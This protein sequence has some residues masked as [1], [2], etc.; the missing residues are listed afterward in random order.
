MPLL[1]IIKPLFP[2]VPNMPG[3]PAIARS[4]TASPVV[5]A[6]LGKVQGEIWRALTTEKRWGIFTTAGKPVAVADSVIDIGFK[7]AAKVSNFPIQAGSFANHNKVNNPFEVT[8][9][10]AKGGSLSADTELANL[11]KGGS[12]GGGGDRAR[13]EFLDAIDMAKNSL[14][15]F[16][17]VTP[18]KT[19]SSC[20]IIGYSY[21]REQ[22]NGAYMLLVDITLI[23]IRQVYAQYTKTENPQATI[24]DGQSVN[25]ASPSVTG[26]VQ[27]QEVKKSSALNS[28]VTKAIS[29]F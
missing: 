3:V 22:G 10:L 19:Y 24:K 28:L 8:V 15:L 5:M 17:V 2:N 9:R 18:E 21:R 16:S 4:K 13:G 26:K 11:L 12:L 20:N 6:I 1:P 25:S 14:D 7:S 23:E 27:G 29:L